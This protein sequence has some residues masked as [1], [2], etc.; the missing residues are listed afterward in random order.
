MVGK[1][2]CPKCGKE[3][4]AYGTQSCLCDLDFCEGQRCGANELFE[5]YKCPNCGAE[6]IPPET[7]DYI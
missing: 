3:A 4:N 6:G 5:R 7:E 2:T 1:I